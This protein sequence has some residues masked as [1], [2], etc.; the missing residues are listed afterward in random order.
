[1]M[2]ETVQVETGANPTGTVIWLHGLGADGH[3][4]EPIVP[5]LRESTDPPLRFIFPHAPVRPVTLNGG[6]P[7]R[8]WYNLYGLDRQAR[9]DDVGIAESDSTVRKLIRRENDRGLP[10]ARIVLAGFSQG[11]AQALYSGTRYRDGLAGI[12]GLSC[13]LPVASR[14]AKERSPANQQ[15]PVVM[16][17]GSFDTVVDPALGAES[18]AF[19]TAA[20]QPVEWHT[21]PMAHAVCPEEITA[22]AGWLRKVLP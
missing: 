17:H 18:R 22:I 20:G 3:D 14:L 16:A 15:T 5:A 12:M 21:Y 6:V 10:S 2:I 11:G 1:L 4:F 9:Q 19:L 13:Y 7:M 8:A